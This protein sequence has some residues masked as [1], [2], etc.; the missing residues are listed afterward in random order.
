MTIDDKGLAELA[1]ERIAQ[2]EKARQELIEAE[3]PGW[4][5]AV[6][7]LI[8]AAGDMADRLEAVARPSPALPADD[9]GLVELIRSRIGEEFDNEAHF[10]ADEAECIAARLDALS[11]REWQDISR[12]AADVLAERR[13]QVEV[14]DWTPDHDDEHSDGSLAFAAACYAISGGVDEVDRSK[15]FRY[16][17]VSHFLWPRSWNWCWWNPKDRRRDLVRA[18]ALIIAEI[19]RLDRAASQPAGG[20]GE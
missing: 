1:R 18:A 19:E 17:A 4:P 13:R 12:A 9:A 20:E 16:L 14:E 2:A 15:N 3:H 11:R 6:L 8:E 5:N 10:T 7:G